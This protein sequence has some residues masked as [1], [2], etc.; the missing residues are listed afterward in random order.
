MKKMLKMVSAVLLAVA[1]TAC[2]HGSKVDFAAARTLK[3]GMTTQEVTTVLGKPYHV[4]SRGDG[5]QIYQWVSVN[6]LLGQ[7]SNMSVIFK[8]G[9]A[10]SVP[11]IPDSF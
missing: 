8:D 10:T 7:N 2:A 6:L 11:E 9:I 3:K 5:V 4:S 1:M